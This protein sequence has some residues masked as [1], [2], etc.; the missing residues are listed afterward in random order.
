MRRARTHPLMLSTMLPAEAMPP[1]CHPVILSKEPVASV[2]A[3][4]PSVA[5]RA[6][7]HPLV[8]L[9]RVVAARL[10][11]DAHGRT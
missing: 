5:A 8:L 6:A 3:S 4:M 2:A 11:T 10:G 7:A 9:E 1:S